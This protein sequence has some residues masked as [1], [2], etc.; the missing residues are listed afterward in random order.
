MHPPHPQVCCLSSCL[1][2][3]LRMHILCQIQH[4]H[5][6]DFWCVFERASPCLVSFP[7]PESSKG[8]S[9]RGQA[10]VTASLSLADQ[11]LV[12]GQAGGRVAQTI[13]LDTGHGTPHPFY[14]SIAHPVWGTGHLV[15]CY[16][17][18]CNILPVIVGKEHEIEAVEGRKREGKGQDWTSLLS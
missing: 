8:P 7:S 1:S 13:G 17:C 18:C 14:S 16:Y 10:A 12:P 2:A 9:I 4:R 5:K 3:C 15:M 11:H 6:Q